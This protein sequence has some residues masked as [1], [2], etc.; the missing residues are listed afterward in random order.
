[1]HCFLGRLATVAI[2]AI[3]ASSFTM[4]GLNNPR[5]VNSN[6][7]TW[8]PPGWVFSVVWTLIYILFA[9]AWSV[10]PS[11]LY[12]VN[13]ILNVLWTYIFFVLGNWELAF[14]VLILLDLVLI[15]Q[16]QQTKLLVPYL[17]WTLFATV[18]NWKM[19][20]LNPKRLSPVQ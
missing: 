20:K 11:N 12:W 18:L 15:I 3:I 14:V 1:M 4:K 7:P 17:L 5:Y 9:Y 16:V 10:S 2:G 13:L 6:K 19:I 8:Y